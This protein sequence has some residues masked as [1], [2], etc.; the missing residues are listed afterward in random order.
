MNITQRGR[1][2]IEQIAARPP[3]IPA[4]LSSLAVRPPSAK[5][6]ANERGPSRRLVDFT[7]KHG[8]VEGSRHIL[9]RNASRA[10]INELTEELRLAQQILA[11]GGLTVVDG[12]DVLITAYN[13]NM[14]VRRR[15]G[16]LYRV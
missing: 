4:G 1:D 6:R 15:D 5:R 8:R 3:P 16:G 9:D 10:L 2:L 11:K 13:V 12:G 7:L 14:A